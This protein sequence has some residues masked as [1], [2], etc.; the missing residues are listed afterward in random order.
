M[1]G[2]PSAASLDHYPAAARPIA[3]PLVD[4]EPAA[5]WI[6]RRPPLKALAH[7]EPLGHARRS[8]GRSGEAGI[9]RS[10]DAARAVS[11]STAGTGRGSISPGR[12][13]ASLRPHD[14][15]YQVAAWGS[16]LASLAIQEVHCVWTFS[17]KCAAVLHIRLVEH[18]GHVLRAPQEKGTSRSA[19]QPSQ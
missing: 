4:H 18:A 15:A 14:P 13:S 17:T 6:S 1:P 7:R 3:T 9:D 5:R 10:Q 2:V 11:H 19:P 8:S 16:V 12:F